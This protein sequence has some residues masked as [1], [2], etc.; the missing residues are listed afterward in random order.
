M[1]R[2]NIFDYALQLRNLFLLALTRFKL[3]VPCSHSL[4]PKD[5]EL[6]QLSPMPRFLFADYVLGPLILS[7]LL[8]VQLQHLTLHS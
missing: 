5:F 8:L 1:P 3:S 4:A 6:K 2:F 7:L